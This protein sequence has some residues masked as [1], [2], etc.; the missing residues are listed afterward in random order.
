MDNDLKIV[1][2]IKNSI[3]TLRFKLE[4]FGTHIESL[5]QGNKIIRDIVEQGKPAAIVR[6][7]S[8]E[9]HCVV[10]WMTNSVA[11]K[12]TLSNG[13]FCAGIFPPDIEHN[14]EFS[15]IYLESAKV[16]DV[17]ALCDVYREKKIVTTYCPEATFIRARSIEPYYFQEP[18]TQALKDKKVLIVHPFVETIAKQYQRRA[19]L[20]DNKK[21][22]PKFQSIDFVKAVQSAAGAESGF[23]CWKEALKYM[24]EEIDKKDFEI[25]IIGAGAYA[26]PLCMHIKS[27]GKIAIQMSG[28]TQILF[29]I[30]GKRWDEHPIISKLYNEFW[31]RPSVEETPV[32]TEKVE[33]GSYW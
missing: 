14:A 18:W 31:V 28:S 3:K 20:F 2:I 16:A 15:K 29:G 12:E 11:S 7:G 33:G 21:V 19:Q 22:L 32:Q 8:V 10:P 17:M 9:A 27:M 23:S 5:E 25:A 24:C 6:L 30:K 26:M 4:Y 1:K 13:M